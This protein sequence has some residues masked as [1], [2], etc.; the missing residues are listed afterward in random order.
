MTEWH[1]PDL[2]WWRPARRSAKLDV[3]AAAYGASAP[4][5]DPLSPTG[6][7]IVASMQPRRQQLPP[8]KAPASP[9]RARG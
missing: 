3:F 8:N 2:D 5:Q 9:K 1:M 4:V 6:R 7:S